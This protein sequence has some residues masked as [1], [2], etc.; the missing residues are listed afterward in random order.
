M[1]TQTEATEKEMHVFRKVF[2]QTIK[3]NFDS[4]MNLAAPVDD[5]DG[6]VKICV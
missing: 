4:V 1:Q 6:V 2:D 5:G 3:R